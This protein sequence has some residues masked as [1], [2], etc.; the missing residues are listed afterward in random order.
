MLKTYLAIPVGDE[1]Y[2]LLVLRRL[3]Y[4][5]ALCLPGEIL[6]VPVLATCVTLTRGANAPCRP[7]DDRTAKDIELA[8]LLA[9]A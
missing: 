7:A 4:Q 2:R 9:E 5:G 6:L 1:R 3:R 8:R